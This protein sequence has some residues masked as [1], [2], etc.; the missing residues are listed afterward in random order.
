MGS[1]GN[2]EDNASELKSYFSLRKI[3]DATSEYSDA[4]YVIFGVPF[5]NTSSFRRGSRLAPDAI[6]LAYDNLES[7]E[8]AYDVDFASLGMSDLGNLQVTEDAE[9][10][11]DYVQSVTKMILDDGKIPIMLGGEH[12]I[13]TGIIRN[14]PDVNLVIIDAHSDFRYEYF[15]NKFN[16]ACVTRRA[17]EILGPNR[18]TSIGTRSVSLEEIRSPEWK[19]VTFIPAREVNRKG[20]EFAIRQILAQDPEKIYLSIDMDGVD[21]SFAPGV[22]TPEPYGLNHTDVCDLIEA[23]SGRMVGMDIVEI[24]PV[25]DNGNTSMLAAKFI[26]NFIGAKETVRRKKE[27]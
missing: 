27:L 26:Q 24:T 1:H 11:V 12:S 16:H 5:D 15:G 7:Y 23:I 9:E 13:T 25:Y 18:I 17:L 10:V 2:K 3:A 22:G 6:R 4:K 14:L 20:I 21:P 8:F 19:D